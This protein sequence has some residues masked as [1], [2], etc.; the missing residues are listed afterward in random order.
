[1]SIK[2]LID[3]NLS[4]EWVNVFKLHNLS[5][6]QWS[7][8]GDPKADDYTILTWADQHD[9]VI[10]TQDLDFSEILPTTRAA[11]PSVIQLRSQDILPVDLPTLSSLPFNNLNSCFCGGPCCD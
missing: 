3:M 6:I 2:I 1:M 9:Y 8:I 5:A 4:P 11:A 10:F 7:E